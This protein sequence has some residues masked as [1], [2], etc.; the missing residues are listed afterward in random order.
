MQVIDL[1]GQKFGY[2]TVLERAENKNGRAQWKCQCECGNTVIIPSS[3][4]RHK[5]RPR[6]YCSNQCIL[7]TKPINLT[8]QRFG[9][10]TAI[11]LDNNSDNKYNSYGAKWICRCDCGKEKIV[12]SHDLRDGKVRSCGCLRA[13]DLSSRRTLQLLGQHF[14]KLTVIEYL[15]NENGHSKWKC[16]CD[17][18]NIIETYSTNLVNQHKGSCGCLTSNGESKIIEILNNLQYNFIQQYSFSDLLSE[19]NSPLRFDFAIINENSAITCL[20]EFDGIQHFQEVDYF[21]QTL[22]Q[23][24]FRDNLKN[25]YCKK[26]NI[27]LIRFNYLEL[28]QNLLTESYVLNKINKGIE[29]YDA[30]W[31]A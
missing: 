22:E 16:K 2:L 8:G 19:N 5:D 28:N 20:I 30:N 25:I 18:G 10:L 11:Q 24:Q 7:K 1:T 23:I 14:G 21:Q 27:P 12:A 6:I 3:D 9:R 4:L 15:S 29:Q 31:M 26:H 17:C 13:E